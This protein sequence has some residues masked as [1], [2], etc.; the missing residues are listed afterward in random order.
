M[1]LVSLP[2]Y[3]EGEMDEGRE[4]FLVVA[5]VVDGE[6]FRAVIEISNRY[7]CRT[8]SRERDWNLNR[9]CAEQDLH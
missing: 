7:H 5:S 2:G 3:P 6:L 8:F 4:I 9:H 1:L